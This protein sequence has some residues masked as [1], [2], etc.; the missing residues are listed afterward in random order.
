MLCVLGGLA[1]PLVR[2]DDLKL[3]AT[4]GIG[5][6]Y[7]T[8][9][10]L[11]VTVSIVNTGSQP[12]HGQVQVFDDDTLGNADSL[13]AR[14]ADVAASGPAPQIFQVYVRNSDPARADVVA[15]LVSGAGRGGGRVL[16]KANSLS[17]TGHSDFSGLAVADKDLLLVGFSADT[18]A[19]TFLNGQ[20]WGLMHTVGGLAFR[21]NLPASRRP[22][23]S[24][25][26]NGAIRPVFRPSPP[27]PPN[28]PT[29]PPATAAWTPSCCEPTPRWT[30]SPRPR[31]T[32]SRHG[33]PAADT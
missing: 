30:R 7:R 6:R 3:S 12:V 8:G 27:R 23:H 13:F 10:W 33:S 29:G 21:D 4:L 9:T 24:R 25:L 28:C 18:S 20:K 15:Q 31:R 1:P 22:A 5:G 11:P 17:T 14:P 32:P 16:A 26:D 2:A 19:F